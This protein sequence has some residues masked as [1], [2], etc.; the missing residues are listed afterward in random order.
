[1]AYFWHTRRFLLPLPVLRVWGYCRD[2]KPNQR[3]RG[4]T[5]SGPGFFMHKDCNGRR[6]PQYE[7]RRQVPG[8]Q[9]AKVPLPEISSN[10]QPIP[11]GKRSVLL[12]VHFEFIREMN[13]VVN[14]PVCQ[15]SHPDEPDLLG[16]SPVQSKGRVCRVKLSDQVPF[17]C[18]QAYRVVLVN[19][20][21]SG[22]IIHLPL[23]SIVKN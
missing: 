15:R 7:V 22:S 2:G 12:S 23:P 17:F 14:T 19:G 8:W 9:L 20:I 18:C 11:A 4:W 21:N 3:N 6:S 1:M 10:Y 5:R 13:W 16:C